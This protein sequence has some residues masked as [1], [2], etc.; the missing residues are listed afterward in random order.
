MNTSKLNRLFKKCLVSH[1][2]WKWIVCLLCA[3]LSIIVPNAP[4]SSM[5]EV[6][7]AVGFI[8]LLLGIDILPRRKRR[9]IKKLKDVE[10]IVQQTQKDIKENTA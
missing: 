5:F 8:D 4:L 1:N 6:M 10:K 2:Q 3:I 7:A 9:A